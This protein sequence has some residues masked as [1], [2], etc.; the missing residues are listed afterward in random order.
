M[1]QPRHLDRAPIREA[2]FDVRVD[3][4]EA[5]ALDDL[6]DLAESLEDFPT[7]Q[8][9]YRA[10]VGIEVREKGEF[11]REDR[12][13]PHGL[14]VISSDQTRILQLRLDGF[15]YSRL[16]PYTSW[17]QLREEAAA[18]LHPYAE[19]MDGVEAT[20]LALRYINHLRLPYPT[21]DLAEY[22]LG[23]PELP[24]EWPQ[25]VESFL[26]RVTLSDE[27]DSSAHVSHALVDDVDEDRIGVIF[28]IDAFR[29]GSFA[30]GEDEF[31]ETFEELHDL[32]NRI[33][34]GGITERTAEI[35]A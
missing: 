14:R 23:L 5:A 16:A 29:E 11:T 26:Y 27:S 30:I 12:A 15:S 10:E 1:A 20:R 24:G 9:T 33:F 19:V 4:A 28:D 7:V 21:A 31:W 6:R 34:F 35:H 18:Y 17:D 25:T 13:A 3:R 8:H 22:I 2:V 32:K